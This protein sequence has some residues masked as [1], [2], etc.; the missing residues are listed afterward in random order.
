MKQLQKN[1]PADGPLD[2]GHW[3]YSD[4]SL[5]VCDVPF[6][7]IYQIE[8][9]LTG[10]KYIGKKQC[11]T[12]LKRKALKGKTR[13]RHEIAETDWK[14]Y[15]S[16]SRELNEDIIKYGKENFTF[17]ILKWCDSKAELGYYEIKLQLEVDA[18]LRD[19]YYNGIIN[20]RLRTFRKKS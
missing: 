9:K 10:R 1:D 7:F 17:S 5:V 3:A 6:G 20:C 4:E 8:N 2:L 14:S 11:Q 13:K 19:D 12:I 15:T 16:S 18:L